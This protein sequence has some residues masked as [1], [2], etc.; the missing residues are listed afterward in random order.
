[1]KRHLAEPRTI[2]FVHNNNDLYGAEVILLQL[3]KGLDRSRFSPVVVLPTDTKHI[4][5]L[6]ARL[7]QEGLEYH[8]IRMGVIRRKYFNLI[9]LARYVSD[10]LLGVLNLVT[11]IR[12]RNVSLVHSNTIAV[13]CGALAAWITRTPH[14]WHIHEIIVEPVMARKVMHFLGCH[15]PGVVVAV[16]GSVR[17][18]ILADCPTAAEK[19]KVIRNGID[20]APFLLKPDGHKIR[21]GFG[22]ASNTLL[23]GMVGKVC[24]WKGQLLFLEAAKLAI[25]AKPELYFIAVGGV[26][27]DEVV[28]MERFREAVDRSGLQGRFIVSDFRSDV[29]EI[30][31]SFD[32][33]VLP[34][35]QPDPF[36]TVVLEAMAAAKPVIAAAHGGSKEIV[37]QEETGYLVPPNDARALA[38]AILKLAND[39]IRAA[40][41]G[42]AG[43]QRAWERFRA[44]RYVSEFHQLYSG[45]LNKGSIPEIVESPTVGL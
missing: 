14:V 9:G 17:D 3:L 44:E 37:C 40:S 38:E 28:Y 20:C 29:R 4:N 24:R 39:P 12:R 30:M 42:R 15:L 22:V 31:K 43:R 13:V 2:L 10:V 8:F 35:T 19:I 11:L 16:S 21:E 7:D 23:V 33:F 32:V 41:M 45:L 26:F 18:H 1:M 25:Q 5:R 6:S 36:P 27:D 34:S